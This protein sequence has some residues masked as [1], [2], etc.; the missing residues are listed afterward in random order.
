M[1]LADRDYL[2][3]SH[4]PPRG[5]GRLRG[6]I[7]VNSWLIIICVSVFVLDV[8]L[9]PRWVPAGRWVPYPNVDASQIDRPRLGKRIVESTQDVV[10][11]GTN[12]V[13]T[14][15]LR[16]REVTD[17]SG[18]PIGLARLKPMPYLESWFYFST[19]TMIHGWNWWRVITFQFL[20]DHTVFVHL[21]FNMMGLW[22]FGPL[23]EQ[24]LGGKRYLAFYLLCGICGALMYLLLNVLGMVGVQLFGPDFSMPFLLFNDMKTPLIGASAGVFGVL[25]AGAYLAPNETVLL[26]FIIPMR[27][28]VLAYLLVAFSLV[29][30]AFSLRNAGG[31]AAHLGGA[32]AGFYFIRHPHHL[33]GFFDV[34]GR[35]DPTSRSGK[36]RRA[37]GVKAPIATAA[38][39]DRILDKIRTTG[40]ASLT[41]SERR[42]LRDAAAR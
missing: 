16:Q 20:H 31:E 41:E 15:V 1:G 26:F 24:H 19:D 6:R 3:T 33:H 38:E 9:P 11:P 5:R 21:L 25:M 28:A 8:F 2:R 42:T 12:R 39:I 17:A 23:V 27:F 30:L 34:L 10:I 14:L 37:S 22:F 18:N 32:L 29:S 4:S 36:L 35:V 7:T 40:M 13:R